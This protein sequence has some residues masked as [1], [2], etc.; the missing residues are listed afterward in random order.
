MNSISELEAPTIPKAKKSDDIYVLAD[1]YQ[2]DC[3]MAVFQRVLNS[4]LTAALNDELHSTKCQ[5]ITEKVTPQSCKED[6]LN[7]LPDTGFSELLAQDVTNL[8][9][10]FATL[11]DQK[12]VGLRLAI[13][14]HAMCP[15]FHVDHIPCRL[16]TTYSGPASQ[17]L[18]A[19]HN[20][21]EVQK[22]QFDMAK[23]QSLSV[24]DVAL[25]KGEGWQGNEGFGL[26]HRSPALRSDQKRL[27]LTL[28]LLN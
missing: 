14:D 2:P 17:W 19:E 25:L 28:D 8:V 20:L 13:S 5:A 1:I 7:R 4:Q 22:N 9:D 23:V 10:M 6:L 12:R 27:I 18:N 11:F 24:A 26:I 16:V 3:H 15:N 21:D